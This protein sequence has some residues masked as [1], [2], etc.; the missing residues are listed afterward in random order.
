MINK[1]AFSQEDMS[2][3]PIALTTSSPNSPINDGSRNASSTFNP[4]TAPNCARC[5]NHGLKIALKG[6]KRYCRYWNCVCEKCVQ[7]STRQKVMARETA[8]RRA[9]KLHETKVMEYRKAQ[10]LARLTGKKSPEPPLELLSPI[11]S[12]EPRDSVH[13]VSDVVDMDRSSPGSNSVSDSIGYPL[14]HNKNSITNSFGNGSSL[15]G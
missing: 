6:H 10:E 7:T 13:S 3:C 5:K 12:P 2:G 15:V 4:R 11:L 8:H 9:R 1:G 14:S